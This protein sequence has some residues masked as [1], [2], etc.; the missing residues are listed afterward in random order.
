MKSVGE[1]TKWKC[2]RRRSDIINDLHHGVDVIRYMFDDSSNDGVRGERAEMNMRG[3]E[4]MCRQGYS[5]RHAQWGR[6]GGG[7]DD[8]E[9]RLGRSKNT[10]A[11]EVEGELGYTE[12]KI[13]SFSCDAAQVQPRLL[14]P[15]RPVLP[16]QTSAFD[17]QLE[18]RKSIENP[19]GAGEDR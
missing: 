4:L 18:R 9:Q 14:P 19:E 17:S 12:Q 5:R 13:F 8:G 10:T 16:N 3:G 1:K 2:R 7:S 15:V 6:C 11:F